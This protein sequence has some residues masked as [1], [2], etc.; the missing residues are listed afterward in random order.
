MTSTISHIVLDVCVILQ[1]LV[2]FRSF[3]RGQNKS[4][5]KKF[6]MD[7]FSESLDKFLK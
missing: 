2:I 7:A 5:D 4:S 3:F 1:F 6:Q